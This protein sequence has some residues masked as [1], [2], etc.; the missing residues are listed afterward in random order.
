MQ[1]A[2]A[3]G[4][5]SDVTQTT[6]HGRPRRLPLVAL[7]LA[8]A[9][10]LSACQITSPITTNMEYDPADG[11][12]VQTQ[13]VEVLDLVV[14]SEGEGA[15]GV[16]AG[17][18]VNNSDEEETVDFALDADGERTALSPTVEIAAGNSARTDGRQVDAAEFTDP[19][20]ID[21][22]PAVA[23]SLV[24]VRVTTSADGTASKRVP[25]LPPEGVYEPY[26]ELIAG[27]GSSE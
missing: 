13:F 17:Y 2:E 20:L 12:S 8:A 19:I 3:P 24:T 22:V 21:A 25:V 6:T 16:L 27:A 15:P 23:G 9:C 4:R 7:T 11:V 26:A 14:V 18:V 1:R 10:G 5:L